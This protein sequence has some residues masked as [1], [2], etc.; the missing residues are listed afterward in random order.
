MK[1]AAVLLACAVSLAGFTRPASAGDPSAAVDAALVAAKAGD[2]DAAESAL[3][4][5]LVADPLF[6]PA[7]RLRDLFSHRREGRV[8][9]AAFERVVAGLASRRSGD[10]VS[11]RRAFAEGA[12]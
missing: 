6:E 1:Q 9:E 5:A 8:S 3:Q 11:A 4:D 12:R 2:L 7:L 10:T